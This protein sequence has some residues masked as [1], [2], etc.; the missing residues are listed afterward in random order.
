[1]GIKSTF[2]I[3]EKK[4][5]VLEHHLGGLRVHVPG[6]IQQKFGGISVFAIFSSQSSHYALM[7]L[8]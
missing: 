8:F 6:P 7:C 3:Q 4:G 2:V 5:Q 1:M